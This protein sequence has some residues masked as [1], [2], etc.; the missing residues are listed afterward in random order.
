VFGEMRELGSHAPE[1]HRELGKAVGAAGFDEVLFV[2]PSQAEFAAGLRSGG[3][4]KNPILSMTY[5]QNLATQVLPV[6]DGKDIV[7]IKGSRG[8][9]LEKALADLKPLNFKAK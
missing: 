9:E 1:L 7:L 2:G 3:F 6:L 8:M 4:S 5:E